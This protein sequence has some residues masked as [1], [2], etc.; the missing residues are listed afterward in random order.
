MV[1]VSH[2]FLQ[3]LLLGSIARAQRFACEPCIVR[4]KVKVK[5]IVHGTQTSIFWQQARAAML[6]AAR[7]MRINMNVEL[8]ETLDTSVMAA[9]ILA[10]ASSD[11]EPDGLIVTM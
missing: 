7:D 3:I 8:Y 5:A 6:Q 9:E 10:A 11:P 4:E 1:K 2:T